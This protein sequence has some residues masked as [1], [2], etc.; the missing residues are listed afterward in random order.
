[1]K[2]LSIFDFQ[3]L[4][5]TAGFVASKIGKF[6]ICPPPLLDS[7]HDA[8]RD[9]KIYYG[10]A[11]IRRQEVEITSGDVTGVVHGDQSCR[12][13]AVCYGKISF[14]CT[15]GNVRRNGREK[16]IVSI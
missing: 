8:T 10:A 2:L 6:W 4:K 7:C 3:N 16:E 11:V 1:M 13:R 9:F 15:I 5:Q 12:I 14:S